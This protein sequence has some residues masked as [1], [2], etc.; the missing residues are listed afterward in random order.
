MCT[1]ND[2]AT[3]LTCVDSNPP[4]KTECSEQSKP[5]TPPIKQATLDDEISHQDISRKE[6]PCSTT[7]HNVG[8]GFKRPYDT[9][10]IAAI[11][12]AP[13]PFVKAIVPELMV[14]QPGTIYHKHTEAQGTT[15]AI[16]RVRNY[17]IIGTS[18]IF[19]EPCK[20]L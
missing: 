18:Q 16:Y 3:T 11:V 8:N 20:T 5:T 6:I 13:A 14:S 4:N 2:I 10:K 17:H 15:L 1:G 19:R 9:M 7:A 12:A